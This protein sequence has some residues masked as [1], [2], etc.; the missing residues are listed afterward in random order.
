M[1]D[2]DKPHIFLNIYIKFYISYNEKQK[3]VGSYKHL[4]Q[5]FLNIMLKAI[6][7]VQHQVLKGKYKI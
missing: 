2:E 5:I 1:M 7:K 6:V 4:T 3:D